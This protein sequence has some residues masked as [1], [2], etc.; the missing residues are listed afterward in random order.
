MMNVPGDFQKCTLNYFRH[1]K[2]ISK[3]KYNQY[4]GVQYL[5]K[6]MKHYPYD[7][8]SLALLL[9]HYTP[10]LALRDKHCCNLD[11]CHSLAFL[12]LRLIFISFLHAQIFEIFCCEHIPFPEKKCPVIFIISKNPRENQAWKQNKK[13]LLK[14]ALD[15]LPSSWWVLWPLLPQLSLPAPL[16]SSR[17]PLA[18]KDS[19]S[20]SP[21]S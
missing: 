7:W 12:G 8:W 16:T 13:C 19:F 11:V 20:S 17:E 18:R 15:G 21:A 14:T 6:E 2:N 4:P 5:A 1:I 3:N 9:I 10:P